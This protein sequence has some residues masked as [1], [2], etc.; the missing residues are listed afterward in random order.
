LNHPNDNSENVSTGLEY[1]W[2]NIFFI[3]GGYKINVDEQ[4]YTFGAGLKVPI[5]IA[6]FTFDYAYANFSRL[7][8]AHRF[9]II[10]G[11]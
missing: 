3:R 5:S 10:L 4:N 9:S 2:K 1:A 8:S 7:G 6:E 11:L